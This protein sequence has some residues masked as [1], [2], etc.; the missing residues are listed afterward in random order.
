MI[1]AWRPV[2]P[3]RAAPSHR[4]RVAIARSPRRSPGYAPG[5]TD[6]PSPA[7]GAAARRILVAELLA[8]W[9]G[10]TPGDCSL[11]DT[12]DQG[13]GELHDDLQDPYRLFRCRT[14]LN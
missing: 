1:P 12:S 8:V 5:M 11:V 7:P 6:A 9:A 2:A 14:S 10:L 3:G 4:A 13:T